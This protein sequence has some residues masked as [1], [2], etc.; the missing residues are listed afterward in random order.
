MLQ[1]HG[2]IRHPCILLVHGVIMASI[3]ATGP[4]SNMAY[5]QVTSLGSII[6]SMH[7]IM[8]RHGT[9]PWSNMAYICMLLV[10]GVI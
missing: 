3:H 5:M 1:V 6:A 8:S 7:A 4:W 2:V 10:H 9:G